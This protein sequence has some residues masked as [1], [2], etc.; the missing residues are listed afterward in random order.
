MK[1]DMLEFLNK[2]ILCVVSTVTEASLPESA[3]VGFICNDKLEMFFGTS[4][5]SRKY[6]NLVTNPAAAVVVADTTAEVQ[7]EGQAKEVSAEDYKAL[8]SNGDCKELPGYA[9]Y[10]DDP[11]QAYFRISP[12]WIRFIQHGETDTVNEMTEF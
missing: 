2:H 1:D 7:Y 5:Q 3:Y 11:N 6:K 9:K 8:V 4:N 10:R 12:T